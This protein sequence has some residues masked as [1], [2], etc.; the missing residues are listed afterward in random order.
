MA[1]YTQENRRSGITT[2]LGKDVLLL[3]QFEG[4]EPISGLFQ[5]SLNL[6]SEND[7]ISARSIIGKP[8]AFWVEH[9]DGEPRW[10][11]GMVSRFE[12]FGRGDR[13]S[14]YRAQVVP[15]L[16][17]L[18]LN[19][20]CRIFQEMTVPDIIADVLKRR[21]LD[22]FDMGGVTGSYP[23]LEYCVQYN[24]SDFAFISRLMEEVGI[25][26]FFQHSEEG[27]KMMIGDENGTFMAAKDGDVRFVD[28]LSERSYNNQIWSWHHTYEFRPG[29]W[30]HKDFNFKD[31][32]P[33]SST[34]NSLISLQGN[35]AIEVYEYPGGFEVR[36]EGDS[37]AKVRMEAEEAHHDIVEGDSYCRSFS[38]GYTFRMSGHHSEAESNREYLITAVRHRLDASAQYTTGASS[39]TQGY[40]NE[41][42][43][44]PKEI[45]FR[46]LRKTQ[47]PRI[48]GTQTALVVGPAGEEIYT[49]EFGRVKVQFHWDR[50]G[51]YNE[52]SSCWLRVS[53]VHAGKGWGMMDLPRIGEEVIV[54]FLEGD[55]DRPLIVGRVYNGVNTVPFNLPAEKTRRGNMTKTYKGAGHNEMSM[56]DTPGKEQLRMNAQYDMNSNVNNDQTLDVGKNQTEKVG[57][58]RTREVG[59]NETVKVGVN[60]SVNV[61]TNHDETIGVNQKISVG[62]SQT[63]S[64]GSTQ[65][66]SVGSMKN[67]TVGMM[68]N[69]MVGVA[70]TLNVGAAYSIISGG[71]MNVAVGFAA[72]EEVGG[73]KKIIVGSKLEI[74]CGA[75]KLT[76]DSGGKVTISGTEFN[77]SASGPV[78]INGAIIDLN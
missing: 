12:Y 24:E 67:E 8:V 38:P 18:S 34:K 4:T 75:S 56:D 51:K 46:P 77:F 16:W 42:T 6:L 39:E 28:K 21:G 76:M 63:T 1:N 69:E 73:T 43:C 23:T 26:Y 49:D 32:K 64:V 41:F 29:K 7:A 44:V 15:A 57:V 72:A 10:F 27:H 14:I 65:S 74:T 19:S 48:H 50:E 68:S 37:R 11:H 52:S 30:A 33:M 78:K 53:Q 40:E 3:S 25:F 58:D 9:P 17:F 2:S 62:T 20:D 61:G 54:S 31:P 55:P 59:N 35:S 71:V 5:Y 36:D 47:V 22:D 45:P 60:K 66:N 13:L 70:K